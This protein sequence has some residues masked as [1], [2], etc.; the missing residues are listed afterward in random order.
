[1]KI[2]NDKLVDNDGRNVPFDETPNK[3]GTL[4][5]GRPSYIII[6]YTASGSA[7]SAINTFNNPNAK[8]SAHI[9]LGHDGAITQMAKFDERCWHAGKSRWRNING[10][11]SHSVG[12]EIVNWGLL[13]GEPGNW[14]SWVGTRILDERVI[15]AAHSFDGVVRGWEI[16]DEIQINRAAE[17]V[18]ALAEEYGLGPEHVLGHDD[19]SPGRKQ[20][21]GPAW[22]MERFKAMT[23]GRDDDHGDF[24]LKYVVD[25]NSGL[26]MRV[27]GGVEHAKI[28]TLDNGTEVIRVETSGAWWLVSELVNGQADQ[29]GWVHSN[30]LRQA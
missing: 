24:E 23:F 10:L 26:N 21:P 18:R 13:N 5:G 29:T 14:K 11:N 27:G 30:W 20:D 28:K 25:S 2:R 4:S 3:N 7:Q 15:R 19:I 6:H 12:I 17:I 1:M 16:F 8:A 22:D 9:V